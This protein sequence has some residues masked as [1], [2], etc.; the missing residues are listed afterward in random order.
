[1][2]SLSKLEPKA[3]AARPS[4]ARAALLAVPVAALAVACTNSAH[5][6]SEGSGNGTSAGLCAAA[7]P[8]EYFAEARIVFTGTM[9]P[10]PTASPGGHGFLVSPARV[11]VTQYLKGNGPKIV[12]VATAVVHSGD[13][14]TAVSEDGIQPRA[15][16]HWKIYTSA[17]RMPYDTSIC[18]GT[19][20]IKVRTP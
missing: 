2:R 14:V 17:T 13:G 19:K 3:T 6:S 16:Q 1:M 5:V 8:S 9:L 20:L 11:R 10:G 7:T 4:A 15:G 12:K 18:D